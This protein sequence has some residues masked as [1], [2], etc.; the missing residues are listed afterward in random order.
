LKVQIRFSV[1]LCVLKENAKLIDVGEYARSILL[2]YDNRKSLLAYEK[3]VFFTRSRL[4]LRQKY[5]SVHGE[6]ASWV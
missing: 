5:L 1:F 4:R 3:A 2:P 6:Y